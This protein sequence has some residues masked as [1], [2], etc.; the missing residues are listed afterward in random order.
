[1]AAR[2]QVH[3]RSTAAEGIAT[4][5][6]LSVDKVG[7]G[8]TLVASSPNPTPLT[9][10]TSSGFNVTAGAATQ[11]AFIQQPT[12]VASGAVIS[13]AVT[14]QLRDAG[15]NNVTSPER[16]VTLA[17]G[18]NPSGGVI[19][20]T[21][22][23]T[24][25]NGLATFNNVSIDK[26]GNGYT[27][28]ASSPLPGP[29]LTP[30]ISS[31]FN[32]T[33]GAATQLAFIQQPTAVASGA[34]ISPAVTVQLRD[35]GG[36][37]VTSPERNVTLAIGTNPSGG[38]ISGTVNVTT[39]NGLATFN[40]VSIDKA[41]NGYTLVASSPLPGPALTP[42]ISSGFNVT[43][44]AATQLAFIQQPTAVASG[45]VISPAVTVQLRDAGGNNVTSPERNVTLAIGTNP[46]GG[47]ISGTV[48][49]TTVNGLA[50]FNNVSI[51]K[52]GN[53]YTLVASSPLPGPALTP[54]ISFRL[55]RHGRRGDAACVH[56]AT[57][58]GRLRGGHLSG[59]DGAVAGRRREQ[60]D[61][62]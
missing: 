38:V 47:V 53:G 32:V 25:V 8:Y 59:G 61:V 44:G 5:S 6:T 15:G 41:G 2:F 48:N 51:D 7:S 14:V 57:D 55:Q 21:V 18:T 23:V 54:Q 16:N 43:A 22:N 58:G 30:Q 46:S 40:N 28:V 56:P 33:A 37:N 60:R 24:T 1:M 49:V 17:I 11:L 39:V 26:A 62:S 10:A 20:G 45:A 3:S 9:Q 27:L 50:T 13:P 34:V 19:S 31:G 12:A 29:A 42:Q 36:N 52:A 4:F 35:A